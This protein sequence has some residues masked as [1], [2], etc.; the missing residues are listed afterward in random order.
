MAGYGSAVPVALLSFMLTGR[1]AFD[2]ENTKQI[3]DNQVLGTPMHLQDSFLGQSTGLQSVVKKALA[4]KSSERYLSV[5]A[6]LEDLS[7]SAVAPTANESEKVSE[8]IAG[9]NLVDSEIGHFIIGSVA[10]TCLILTLAIYLW[11]ITSF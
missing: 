11:Y 2:G 1:R 3:L 7:K 6:F 4:H 8:P 9:E 5:T 10:F